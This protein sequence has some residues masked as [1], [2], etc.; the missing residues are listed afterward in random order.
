MKNRV[1]KKL[2]LMFVFGFSV[3]CVQVYCSA[4]A[5]AVEDSLEAL[6]ANLS[7]A[8]AGD[9]AEIEELCTRLVPLLAQINDETRA[10]VSAM[11]G[12]NFQEMCN[13]GVEHPLSGGTAQLSR[14]LGLSSPLVDKLLVVIRNDSSWVAT[15]NT[16]RAIRQV[17]DLTIVSLDLCKVMWTLLSEAYPEES[18]AVAINDCLVGPLLTNIMQ[19]LNTLQNAQEITG[20]LITGLSSIMPNASMLDSF[21]MHSAGFLG[22]VRVLLL[23]IISDEAID[24]RY[25]NAIRELMP[26]VD[27]RLAVSAVV[28]VEGRTVRRESS[29]SSDEETASVVR[30]RSRSRSPGRDGKVVDRDCDRV[31][32]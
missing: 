32:R 11:T 12:K 10:S 26:L 8:P 1:V 4:P 31:G 3:S 16:D 21:Q 19:Y 13:Y 25:R 2:L 23:R 28:S 15:G 5:P 29:D 7:V 22:F 14:S 17:V 27:A 30:R 9:T 24:L 18:A 20:A 6:M